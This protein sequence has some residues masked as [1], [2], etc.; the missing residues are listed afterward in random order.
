MVG[1]SPRRVLSIPRPTAVRLSWESATAW[2]TQAIPGVSARFCRFLAAVGQSPA[3]RRVTQGGCGPVSR[4]ICFDPPTRRRRQRFLRRRSA[5]PDVAIEGRTPRAN[6][7][8]DRRL[9]H[10]QARITVAGGVRASPWAGPDSAP[11]YVSSATAVLRA[12][13][14]TF[15]SASAV[16]AIFVT[17]SDD[18][19]EVFTPTEGRSG[20]PCWPPRPC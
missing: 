5:V 12:S 8:F 17:T 3:R 11:V 13:G 6:R 2:P 10:G 14:R 19:G 18:F 1:R 20:R 4:E 7:D 9:E 16:R 15:A